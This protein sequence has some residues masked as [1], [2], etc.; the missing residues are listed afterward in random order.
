MRHPLDRLLRLR[1]LLEDVSRLELE[2]R[3]QELAQVESALVRAQE[4]GRAMRRQSF[5]GI[6]QGHST[7]RLEAEAVSEWVAWGHG[8]LEKARRGK[9]VEVS[10]AKSAYLERRK[11]CRQVEGVIEA[12]AAADIIERSRREQREL[13][14]WF[15]QESHSSRDRRSGSA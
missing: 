10:A 14:N 11:E 5:V 13:D 12:K 7:E 2:A 6:V 15:G 3:L 4:I 9:T 8:A 1:S